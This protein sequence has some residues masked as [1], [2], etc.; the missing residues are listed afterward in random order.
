MLIGGDTVPLADSLVSYWS[1][2]NVNDS[3][4][5][6]NLTNNNT[7]T[8]VSGKVGN[9]GNFVQASSQYLSIASNSTLEAG[10]IDFTWT[11]WVYLTNTAA[12]RTLIAKWGAASDGDY[13]IQFLTSGTT[14][15]FTAR[16]STNSANAAASAGTLS[17]TTWYFFA[18]RH[19]ATANQI[20]IS[21]DAG[22]PVTAALTG[23]TRVSSN[24][25]AIG[26]LN[27]PGTYHN[28]MLDE[29]GWWKR[30]LSDAEITDL[31]NGGSG[32]DYAYITAA[33]GKAFIYPPHR[34][35]R[36]WTKRR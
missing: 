36:V 6:N 14:V 25:L 26:A 33:A 15:T 4:G 30:H 11:F 31:Y 10:D 35:L 22:T 21:V 5:S 1:L 12:N 32:R 2:A 34:P 19:D 20:S 29:V 8:F 24:A 18:C 7:V 27:T 3:H 28:G 16:N 17:A 23:G 9:A 13:R